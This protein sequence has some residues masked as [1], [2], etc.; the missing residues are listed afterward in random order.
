ML[1][2]TRWNAALGVA[3]ISALVPGAAHA[4]GPA[5]VPV[6]GGQIQHTVTELSWPVSKNTFQHDTLRDERWMG[7]TAGREI[8][9]DVKTG[10]VKWDCQ[11]RL[12]VVRCWDAPITRREPRAGRRPRR[13]ARPRSRARPATTCAPRPAPA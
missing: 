5:H 6:P 10:K 11:F 7:A 12:T 1:L 8:E 2:K 9:T 13:R 3:L 4:A